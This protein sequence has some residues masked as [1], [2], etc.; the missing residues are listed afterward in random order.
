LVG[1][2]VFVDLVSTWAWMALALFIQA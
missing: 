2:L 1:K